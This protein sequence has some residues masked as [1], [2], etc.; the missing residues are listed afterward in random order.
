M[1]N[2]TKNQLI[3]LG[4][5]TSS[6]VPIIT[7]QCSVCTSNDPK[8]QRTRMSVF[9]KTKKQKNILID[10][11]PDAR[12]Q[13]LREKIRH[14]DALIITHSHADHIHGLDDLRAF[15]FNRLEP[16]PVYTDAY[17]I[18][19]LK[20]RFA[21]IFS[22]NKPLGSPVANIKLIEV[23]PKEEYL[24]EGEKFYFEHL[25]HAQM[26]TLS[27]IHESLAYLTDANSIPLTYLEKLKNK[28]IEQLLIDC[29]A[30]NPHRTHL[31]REKSL[32]YAQDI[33]AQNTWLI[34]LSHVFKHQK[35]QEEIKQLNTSTNQFY[36][37]YDGAKI[38]YS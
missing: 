16:L 4:S 12:I 31:H 23:K 32:N 29:A 20:E 26:Q 18:K 30:K 15:T 28:K 11:T 6:G 25:P 24:I 7:C 9:L 5:G 37:S 1:L 34:H 2:P 22:S 14:I 27:F 17:T 33:K 21:Y 13:L 36:V 3:F 35:L 8:D 10:I 19:Q 38:S